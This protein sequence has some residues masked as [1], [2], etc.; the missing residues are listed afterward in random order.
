MGTDAFQCKEVNIIV[1]LLVVLFGIGSWVDINGMFVEIPVFVQHL[2]E[3][4]KLPSYLSIITQM[5]NIGPIF[6]TVMYIVSKKHMWERVAVYTVLCTGAASCLF[7]SFFWKET[8]VIAGDLHSTALLVLHFFLSLTDCTTSVLFLPFM[9]TFKRQYMT[10]YFIGEGLSGLIPSMVALGQGVGQLS[11]K[12]VSTYNKA[13]NST[14]YSA[15]P[16]YHSIRFTVEEFFY[17]LFTMLV[18]SILSFTVLNYT[19][20]CKKEKAKHQDD[21][22][23]RELMNGFELTSDQNTAKLILANDSDELI[24]SSE[25]DSTC[26]YDEDST[27]QHEQDSTRQHDQDSTGQHEQDSIRQHEQDSTRQYLTN[28]H[29]SQSI[30]ITEN[31]SL[32][33]GMFTYYLVIIAW[34]N[35]LSNGTLPALQSYS[36]LPNGNEAYHL[37]ATLAKI[38]NP[39]ACCV[40]C[41]ITVKSRNTISVL[42]FIG[43]NLAG[44]IIYLAIKSPNPAF[45]DTTVGTGIVVSHCLGVSYVLIDFCQSLHSWNLQSRRETGYCGLEAF[46]KLDQQQEQ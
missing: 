20:Y 19:S 11:C 27:C 9:A 3:G 38:S 46:H 10:S 12:N 16:E 44:Y 4:W 41:F 28:I 29:S 17:F 6:I 1:Y 18:I 26:Q 30:E 43:T 13:A 8:T 14:S 37:A 21:C 42:T 5:A 36:T 33:R 32:T 34:V 31:N 7:L 35:C 39:V 45:D 25:Q 23:K 22:R 40:S 15:Q 2:P 24:I